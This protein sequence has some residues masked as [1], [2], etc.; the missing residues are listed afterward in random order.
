MKKQLVALLCPILALVLSLKGQVAIPTDKYIAMLKNGRY[1]EVFDDIQNLRKHKQYAKSATLDYFE[2]KCL[3]FN[4]S[5]EYARAIFN[6]M[7]QAYS[8]TEDQRRF[9]TSE[10]E[11]CQG[12]PAPSGT[13]SPTVIT[14][15]LQ[16]PLPQAILVGK[17]GEVTDC[18]NHNLF[19][20]FSK[21]PSPDSLLKR[22]FEKNKKLDALGF[23]RGLLGIGY[24]IDTSSDRF[25]MITPA[26]SHRAE[27]REAINSLEKAS[28][29]YT[30]YYSLSPPEKLITVFMM[31]DRQALSVAARIVHQIDLPQT[32]LGYSNVGDLSL[33][34]I[35]DIQHIGTL[36]HELFHLT[37]RSDIGDIPVWLDEGLACLYSTYAWEGNI[38]I[39]A[40][41]WRTQV[42]R[43]ASTSKDYSVGV[44]E[45]NTLIGYSWNQFNGIADSNIC[46]AS[47]NY[48]L[49]NHLM[50]YLQQQGLLRK[51]VLR[52]RQG[53]E[54]SFTDSSKFDDSRQ[55]MEAVLGFPMDTLQTKF[56]QWLLAGYGITLSS[57]RYQ[58]PVY[59]FR[60]LL[61]N[62]Q[63]EILQ[64]GNQIDQ[65]V[66]INVANKLNF[67]LIKIK[68]EYYKKYDSAPFLA[69][70]YK[71]EENYQRGVYDGFT[72]T[73]RFKEMKQLYDEAV[74]LSAQIRSACFRSQ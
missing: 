61:N 11:Q 45:L 64:F 47:V 66:T 33:F 7:F 23:W 15:P 21:M 69:Q 5:P 10:M 13:I 26:G 20:D 62:S 25:V 28:S 35:G 37:I 34:G 52:F 39:G 42:L 43:D 70:F 58:M 74:H 19:V 27:M 16:I 57:D 12:S 67:D 3:C 24:E 41:T 49:A 36:F 53:Q 51:I 38:L 30:S 22:T 9:L 63:M 6:K 54:R 65:K 32:S 14:I 48:A 31:P 55:V 18:Y 59:T 56:N 29:F 40:A 46:K 73:Q 8:F 1:G 72:T 71:A 68:E 60:V 44:P 17:I 50:L 2:A 4:G